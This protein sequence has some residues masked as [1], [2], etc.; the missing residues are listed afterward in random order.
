MPEP[1]EGF[2][3]DELAPWEQDQSAGPL[4]ELGL[5]RRLVSE[6]NGLFRW[7][8][9]IRAWIHYD[10]ARWAE[11]LAGAIDRLAK[12]VI[13]QLHGEARFALHGDRQKLT[14]AWLK[15]QT[16]PR[17]RNIIEL[18]RTEPSIP[19]MMSEFDR[20][21]WALNCTNGVVDLRTGELR[22]HDPTEMHSKV[23]PVDYDPKNK[24]PVWLRFLE[25]VFGGDRELTT[26]VQRFAGYSLTGEIR[27]HMFVFG[28]G[29]GANGKTTMFKALRNVAGDYGVQLDPAVLVAGQHEQHPTGLTDLRGAR[30]V[31]TVET[32]GGKRLAE[33]L[34]KQL[35]GGDPIR[36]RRMRCDFFEFTP[37]HHL[38]MAGNHLPT[39]RGTDLGI[40]RRIAL[41]PF[42]VTFEG[43]DQDPD[44]PVKLE[45]EAPGIL[46]WAVQGC[47]EWRQHGLAVPERVKAATADYRTSQDHLGR[48][49][50][51]RCATGDTVYVSAKALRAAY[52]AW[53]H[54]NGENPWSAKAIGNELVTRGFDTTQ[55]GK[56]RTRTWLGIGL[57]SD[58][59][60]DGGERL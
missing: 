60:D 20:D 48:F 1:R 49:L 33:A 46:A 25:E 44:L 59:G 57:V 54:D 18:A 53:C 51:E 17:I 55:I 29:A 42:D 10:G 15:F 28:H 31:F 37:T 47:L 8:P 52:E 12:D 58:H 23:V 6:A 39:I 40:W 16:A 30:L 34:V 24:A 7:A 43:E 45:A 4:T 14:Q 5:A 36:A 26:F 3:V 38:F 41:L 21:P 56:A 35:T 22:P 11:D 9:E 19:V 27:E 13:D 2:D 50:D 32:E